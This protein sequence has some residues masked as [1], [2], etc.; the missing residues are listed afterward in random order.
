MPV[1]IGFAA[2]KGGEGKTFG[3]VNIAGE[4]IARGNRVLIVVCDQQNDLANRYLIDQPKNAKPYDRKNHV[5]LADVLVGKA[6]IQDAIYLSRR[7]PVYEWGESVTKIYRDHGKDVPTRVRER[8]RKAGNMY[9]LEIIPSGDDIYSID[10]YYTNDAPRY[11]LFDEVLAPILNNYDYI[12][13]DIP[14]AEHSISICAYAASD[15]L[16]IPYASIDAPDSVEKMAET[17][18]ML[19]AIPEI[20]HQIRPFVYINKYHAGPLDEALMDI[21]DESLGDIVL[22]HVIRNSREAEFAKADGIPL[23]SYKYTKIGEDIS[24][25]TDEMLERIEEN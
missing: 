19:N 18:D 10:A 22:Q 17:I 3:A 16:M 15:C 24:Y 6:D 21:A 7:Y 12:I 13:F 8:F 5:S 11:H 23:V 20:H 9:Q 25:L 2:R 14:P 4:L 1:K